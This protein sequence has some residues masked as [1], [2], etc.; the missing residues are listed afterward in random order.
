MTKEANKIFYCTNFINQG[1]LKL[2]VDN[3][4]ILKF[5]NILFIGSKVMGLLIIYQWSPWLID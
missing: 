1:K 3:A 5:I 2:E 4:E